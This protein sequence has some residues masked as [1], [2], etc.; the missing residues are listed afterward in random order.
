MSYQ[1]PKS[2]LEFADNLSYFVGILQSLSTVTLYSCQAIWKRAVAS[3][4]LTW[5]ASGLR[6]SRNPKTIKKHLA[7]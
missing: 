3:C 7:W 4:L 1:D 5:D 6:S 2:F